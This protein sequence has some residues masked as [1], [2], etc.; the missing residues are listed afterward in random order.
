LI[1][2]VLSVVDYLLLSAN[3][4]GP[5]LSL[6][7]LRRG[8]L[9]IERA[10]FELLVRAESPDAPRMEGIPDSQ[11]VAWEPNATLQLLSQRSPEHDAELQ[12]TVDWLQGLA[13]APNGGVAVI[14]TNYDIEVEQTLYD[15]LGYRAVFEGVD[16]GV[17]VRDPDSGIVYQRP[18]G[19]RYGVYKLHGSLNWLRCGVCDNVYL[20]PVGAIAYLSFMLGDTDAKIEHPDDL[21]EELERMGADQCHCLARPLRHVIVAPSFV[22]EVRDP[23]LLGV[24][25]SALEA[26]RQADE[27]VIVGYSLPPED[28]RFVRCSSVHSWAATTDV[29]RG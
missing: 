11:R 28:V 3:T 23:V 7:E 5:A 15:R 25:R 10:V 1:T 20:N 19:A 18:A 16:F 27:W 6:A 29:L 26:L 9:L 14:S 2:D 24:W 13:E 21:R 4:P 22:R 17:P 8:R 12:Q